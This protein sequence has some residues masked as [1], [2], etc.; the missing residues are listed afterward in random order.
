M[1]LL[2][3]AVACLPS[4]G[5]TK[6][7]VATSAGGVADSS[8]APL[9]SS[10]VPGPASPSDSLV[11]PVPIAPAVSN[12]CDSAAAIVRDQLSLSIDREDGE[13][14]DSQHGTRYTGCRITAHGAFKALSNRKGG[15]VDIVQNAFIRRGWRPD[16]RHSA[17]G[18]DGSDVG[19][20]RRDIL[21]LVTGSWNGGDDDDTVTRAPTAADDSYRIVVECARDVASNSDGEVPDSLW[22]IAA[23]AGLDSIYA[24]S[25]SLRSPPYFSGDFDGDR[26]E[27]AAVLVEHRTTGKLGVAIVHRGTRKVSVLAAGSGSAGPDDLDG[28]NQMDVFTMGT[29]FNTVIPDRPKAPLI[30][31][32]LWV[33]RDDST[34]GFYLWNGSAFTYEPHR[35]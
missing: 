25:L 5:K 2:A 22:G 28:I 31:D 26:V 35:K 18:P 24:I 3:G 30:G 16:L 27:D 34:T 1:L 19:M 29:A 8:V 12:A 21:C 33:A 17:D 7:T 20:R 11:R 13:Y 32:A 4:E 15:P 6:S 9:Q 23:K 14:R 10:V